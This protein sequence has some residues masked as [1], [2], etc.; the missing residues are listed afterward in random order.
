MW[1]QAPY[2][3]FD[4]GAGF[5]TAATRPPPR[6]HLWNRMTGDYRLET[7]RND[8]VY[9]ALFNVNSRQGDVYENGI[10]LGDSAAAPWLE[11]AYRAFINDTYWLLVPTKL[12]DDGVTR[13]TR[14]DTLG[15]H[16]LTLTFADVGLTPGDTYRLYANP[17]TGAL[18]AWGFVL[19]GNPDAPMSFIERTG[20]VALDTP[21]GTAR[22]ATAHKSGGGRTLYTDAVALPTTVPAGTFTDPTVRMD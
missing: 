11:R 3:R 20:E 9:T 12:F 1:T 5:D 21:H 19:E 17:D 22:L 2:L 13:G 7:T 10:A 8:T 15:R 4:F 14:P 16:V 18:E 6:R